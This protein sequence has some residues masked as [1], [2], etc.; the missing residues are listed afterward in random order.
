MRIPGPCPDTA[1]WKPRVRAR[2]AAFLTRPRECGAS[3]VWLAVLGLGPG[4]AA[5]EL[6]HLDVFELQSPLLRSVNN[7]PNLHIGPQVRCW[8]V[9]RYQINNTLA[10]VN[11][12]NPTEQEETAPSVPPSISSQS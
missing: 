11:T 3:G 1:H 7:T 4:S 12:G 8:G 9:N 5:H 2:E 6:G 10:S